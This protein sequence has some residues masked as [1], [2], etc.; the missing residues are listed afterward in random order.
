[1]KK[2]RIFILGHSGKRGG[3]ESYID[4]LVEI[5]NAE[6]E[7]VYRASI[8][9]IDGKR[10]EAPGNRHNYLKYRRFWIQFFKENNFHAVYFN[11]CDMM[12]IDA[13]IFAKKARVPVRVLHSHTHDNKWLGDHKLFRWLHY[14]SEK[15]NRK[16]L[17]KYAT[18]LLACSEVAG[19]WMFD[20][21]SYSVIKNGINI[22]NYKFSQRNKAKIAKSLG[23]K[24]GSPVIASIGRLSHEKNPLF[25][26]EIFKEICLQNPNA[27]CLF[28]GDGMYRSEIEDKVRR[29]GLS[30][31]ILFTGVVDNVNEWLSYIDA[32]VM[33][34]LFEGLP[35]VLVETQA[36][37]IHC[38]VSDTVSAESNITGLV[39]FKSLNDSPTSWASRLLELSSLPR[40]DVS[41]D[42]HKAGYSMEKTAQSIKDILS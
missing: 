28:I 35:F 23:K 33:P 39:E 40:M 10:W 9:E 32:L 14:L 4:N 25:I 3:V 17:H 24:N 42:L 31:R 34:S 21:R 12:S 8:M 36:A 27:Q 5:L 19:D 13:L 37:G 11:T 2:K 16:N 20:G 30:E 6:Y 38:L 29:A 7:F 26:L 15:F 41:P 1:M 22:N 18:H